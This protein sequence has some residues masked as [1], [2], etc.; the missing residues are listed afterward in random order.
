MGGIGQRA[1]KPYWPW[2]EVSIVVCAV[3]RR[4]RVK[5]G[6]QPS[7]SCIFKSLREEGVWRQGVDD[8]RV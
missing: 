1:G 5:A 2:A 8:S 6:R 4:Q 3:R 7:L